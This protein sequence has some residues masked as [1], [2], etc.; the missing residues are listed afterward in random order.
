MD[1]SFWKQGVLAERDKGF[2]APLQ[3][4]KPWREQLY[5]TAWLDKQKRETKYELGMKK[6]EQNLFLVRESIAAQRS[7]YRMADAH[8]TGLRLM[9]AE[10][11]RARAED[12]LDQKTS[13][14]REGR[15]LPPLRR[16]MPF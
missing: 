16:N 13:F 8:R 7:G 10:M 4:Q 6:R 12:Y 9:K 15:L 3:W 5:P 2:I 14:H 1:T 11:E